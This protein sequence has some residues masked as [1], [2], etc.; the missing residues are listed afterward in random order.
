MWVQILKGDADLRNYVEALDYAIDTTIYV[1]LIQGS[2]NNAEVAR[3][4]KTIS[5]IHLI[6]FDRKV[7]RKTIDLI[8][9]YSKAT[10]SLCPMS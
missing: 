2:K 3:I 6:H 5:F 4:E 10:V 8:R 9:T 7:S 1:E